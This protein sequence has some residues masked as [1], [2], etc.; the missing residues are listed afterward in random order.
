MGAAPLLWLNIIDPAIQNTLV[1][2]AQI[3]SKVVGQ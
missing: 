2:F 1:P 3:A